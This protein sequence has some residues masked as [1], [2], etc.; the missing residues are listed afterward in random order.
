MCVFVCVGTLA[1]AQVGDL[2]QRVF[3]GGD[4]LVVHVQ[5]RSAALRE[6]AVI[7]QQPVQQQQ[8]LSEQ[9]RRRAAP[10]WQRGR[11]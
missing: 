2:P 6:A 1:L 10:P 5:Q 7:H 4:H 9:R 11:S 8:T 3:Y